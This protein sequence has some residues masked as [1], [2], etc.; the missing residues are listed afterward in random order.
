MS[1]TSV[2]TFK[3]LPNKNHV[4]YHDAEMKSEAGAHIC[5]T[6]CQVPN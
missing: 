6:L 2:V 5:K 1:H 4:Q 3:T